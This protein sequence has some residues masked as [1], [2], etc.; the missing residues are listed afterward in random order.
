MLARVEN[1]AQVLDG[2]NDH[3]FDDHAG[4]TIA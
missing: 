3:P 1:P 2:I 4:R